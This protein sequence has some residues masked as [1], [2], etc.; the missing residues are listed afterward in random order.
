MM[1]TLQI[2][3]SDS[4]VVSSCVC[5]NKLIV[6]KRIAGAHILLVWL[7]PWLVTGVPVSWQEE[8]KE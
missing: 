6:F 3:I 5:P 8:E 4:F 7:L 1:E 2:Q